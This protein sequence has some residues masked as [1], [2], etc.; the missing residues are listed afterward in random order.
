MN[1]YLNLRIKI[2]SFDNKQPNIYDDT[3]INQ[4]N[5]AVASNI[6]T[7]LFDNHDPVETA[8]PQ[9]SYN[10]NTPR[11]WRIS[12]LIRQHN[13]E[14]VFEVNDQIIIGRSSK[15][16][17]DFEGVDLSPFSGYE[18]GISRNHAGL[19]LKNEQI[20]LMDHS[21]ANGTLLNYE[22]LR[23]NTMYPV[24]HGD[25]IQF[26]DMEVHVHFLASPFRSG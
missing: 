12:F 20:V 8:E 4:N 10:V 1:Q 9:E 2:M 7:K 23:P 21:S 15:D 6:K 17:Q 19:A 13:V 16:I 26:G 5:F 25:K 11:P 18:L 24:K 14:L 3:L 22:R